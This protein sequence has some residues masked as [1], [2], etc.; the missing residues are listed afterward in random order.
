M[1]KLRGQVDKLEEL[2]VEV[3]PQCTVDEGRQL[4]ITMDQLMADWK[5]VHDD[6]HISHRSVDICVVSLPQY[7]WLEILARLPVCNWLFLGRTGFYL[8]T[9]DFL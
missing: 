8:A 4:R 5:Q 6:F 1:Q 2:R 9:L 3:L 7:I